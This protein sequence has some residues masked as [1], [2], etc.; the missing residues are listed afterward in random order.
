MPNDMDFPIKLIYWKK[1][2]K[3]KSVVENISNSHKCTSKRKGKEKMP[4][5]AW[6]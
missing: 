5:V 4:H 2:K 1:K 3:N 6:K